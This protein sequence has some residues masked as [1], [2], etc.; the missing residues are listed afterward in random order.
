M[1]KLNKI[2]TILLCLTALS[3]FAACGKNKN[4]AQNSAPVSSEQTTGSESNAPSESEDLEPGE[5]DN[6]GG[7]PSSGDLEWDWDYWD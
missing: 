4:E 6:I 1:K 7:I 5:A 2:L 3:L